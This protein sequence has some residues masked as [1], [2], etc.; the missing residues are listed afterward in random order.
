MCPNE[1]RTSIFCDIKEAQ[2]AFGVC[3]KLKPVNPAFTGFFAEGSVGCQLFQMDG[4]IRSYL[5]VEDLV[6]CSATDIP[7]LQ[8][9]CRVY[10]VSD[11]VENN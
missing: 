11:L 7:L 5:S 2:V 3:T 10:F 9:M 6:I 4:G 8:E 1:V